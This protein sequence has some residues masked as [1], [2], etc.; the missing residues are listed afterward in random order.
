MTNAVSRTHELIGIEGVTKADFIRKHWNKQRDLTYKRQNIQKVFNIRIYI[1]KPLKSNIPFS[2]ITMA[3]VK[4]LFS[5]I[6]SA[7]IK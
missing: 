3:G 5:P 1:S 6:S 2:M 4:V 7:A